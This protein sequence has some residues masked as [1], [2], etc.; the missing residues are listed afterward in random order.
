MSI[1]S[2]LQSIFKTFGD[3]FIAEISTKYSLDQDE[4]EALWNDVIEGKKE[5]K[6]A[7]KK[8]KP[9]KKKSEDKPEVEKKSGKCP[10]VLTRGPNAGN[11][12]GK[13][14]KTGEDFCGRHLTMKPKE[15]KAPVSKGVP[16]NIAMRALRM[17]KEIK[18]PYNTENK[19]VFK[20][21]KER[22]VIGRIINDKFVELTEDM[23]ED[24]KKYQYNPPT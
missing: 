11:E 18:R 17:H 16:K 6:P 12:C 5:K 13:N 4:L 19:F 24:C 10:F 14:N 20:S 3:K 1:Y 23:L 22:V 9:V 21:S 8:V 7:V 2:E 15:P